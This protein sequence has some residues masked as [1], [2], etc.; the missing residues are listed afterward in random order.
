MQLVQ[1]T[2]GALPGAVYAVDGDA[3]VMVWSPHWRGEVAPE[4][5]LT[6][7]G[8]IG[9]ATCIGWPSDHSGVN[10]APMFKAARIIAEVPPGASQHM[11]EEALLRAG[12][13]VMPSGSRP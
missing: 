7:V 11:V 4:G 2:G 10:H 5:R 8:M 13:P 9:H 12:L 3:C 6:K 1:E